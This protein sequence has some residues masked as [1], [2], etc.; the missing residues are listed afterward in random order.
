MKAV[1]FHDIVDVRL[2]DVQ[3]SHAAAYQRS[4][5]PVAQGTKRAMGPHER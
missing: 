1:V 5:Q 2:D 4:D 3:G